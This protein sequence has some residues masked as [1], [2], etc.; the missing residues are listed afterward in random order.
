MKK[1]LKRLVRR[2]K[3]V[4]APQTPAKI[5][6]ETMSAHREEVLDNARKYIYPLRH[7]KRR[8]VTLSLSILAVAA[9]LFFTYCTVALYKFQSTSMFLYRVS[10]VI[11]FPIAKAGPNFVAYE[12]YLFEINHYTH[13]YENQQQLDFDSDAG[14][15][16]LQEF[17]KRALDKVVNDAYIKEIANQRGISVSSQEVD[18]EIATVRNQNRLGSSDKEFEDVLK[19]FWGWS[20]DDFRRSLKQQILSQKVLSSLDSNTH[21]RANQAYDQLQ[22]GKDFAKLAKE[23]SEDPSTKNNGGEFGFR[24]EKNNRDISATV[25][26]TLFNLQSGQYSEPIEAGYGLEIVKN[27][28]NKNDKI[29]A[30][31]I[32]FNFKNINEYLNDIKDEKPARTYIS[33]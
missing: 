6:S 31:H 14:Q 22:G 23:V 10:Q 27:L 19:D 15:R 21:D 2:K 33:F 25:V 28:E 30:A 8:L 1:K 3:T 32:V 20:V 24:I 13:Y 18:D 12:N 16:Q 9:V 5:T 7:S 26:D 11:P 4:E 29:R 17:K